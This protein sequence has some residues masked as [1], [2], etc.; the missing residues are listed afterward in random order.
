MRQIACKMLQLR[1]L[2]ST[3]YKCQIRIEAT[4]RKASRT[5]RCFGSRDKLAREDSG[6][7]NRIPQHETGNHHNGRSPYHSPIFNFFAKIELRHFRWIFLQN[8]NYV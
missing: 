8:L 6:N 7:S 4:A 1:Y 3:L 5:V 2:I